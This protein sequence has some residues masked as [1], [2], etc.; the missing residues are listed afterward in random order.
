MY[1]TDYDPQVLTATRANAEKNT[2]QLH[3]LAPEQLPALEADLLLAN[4][5]AQPLPT[6]APLFARHLRTG[7]R[8]VL[9][10]ILE[11]QADEVIAAYQPWFSMLQKIQ[12][13]DWMLLEATRTSAKV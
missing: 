2:V 4:I 3:T 8:I 6:L 1:A 7:G 9:S 12:R 13:D 5:V 11:Q 10:G